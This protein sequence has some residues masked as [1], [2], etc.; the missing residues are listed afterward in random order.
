MEDK[1]VFISWDILL[2]VTGMVVGAGLRERADYASVL[3]VV[4]ERKHIQHNSAVR[5]ITET[6]FSP[7][8]CKRSPHGMQRE[9][10]GLC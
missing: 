3:P 9:S 10:Q 7:I 1:R 4:L 6:N 2:E 8:L 5:F